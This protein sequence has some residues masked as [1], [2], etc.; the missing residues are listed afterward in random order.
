MIDD[1]AARMAAD[2]TEIE[3]TH[4]PFGKYGPQFCPPDGMPIYD[5][6]AEYLMWFANKGGFPKGKLG[7]LLEIVYYMK[8][9]GSESAFDGMRRRNGGRTPLRQERPRSYVTDE[10]GKLRAES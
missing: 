10:S 6:P 2:L 5:L 8:A 7:R 4:M 9:D 3:R 1:L